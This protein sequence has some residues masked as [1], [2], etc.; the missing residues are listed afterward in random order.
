MCVCSS[1]ALNLLGRTR[2]FLKS[3]SWLEKKQNVFSISIALLLLLS[4]MQLYRQ[5]DAAEIKNC[6]NLKDYCGLIE[7]TYCHILEKNQL[8]LFLPYI[9]SSIFQIWFYA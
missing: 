9:V 8:F 6:R 3:P 5:I 2:R 4:S 1:L 7:F